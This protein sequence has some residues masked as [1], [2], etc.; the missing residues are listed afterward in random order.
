MTTKDADDTE[1]SHGKR[2]HVIAAAALEDGERAIIEI[3]GREIAVFRIG[4]E[5]HALLNYCTH[6]GG[7]LCEGLVDGTLSMDE[8]W[9]LTYECEGEIVSCPWHGWEFEIK[10][11]RHLSHSRYRIPTYETELDDG[12]VY[13]RV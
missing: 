6:Q 2:H 1:R 8:N 9:E 13:V 10:T 12:E 7:P 4:D 5:F 3:E 11:G